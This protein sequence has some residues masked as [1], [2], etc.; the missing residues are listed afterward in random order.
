MV[1]YKLYKYHQIDSN[2]YIIIKPNRKII[3]FCN[4]PNFYGPGMNNILSN[5]KFNSNDHIYIIV[6][7][8]WAYWV[9]INKFLKY[10]KKSK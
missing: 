3:P 5:F 1:L 7:I 10:I 2:W 9:L 4:K 8:L 6:Y